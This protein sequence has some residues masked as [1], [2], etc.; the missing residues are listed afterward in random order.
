LGLLISLGSSSAINNI[1]AGLVI[2]YMR[3]FKIGDRI[4]IGDV[5]GDVIEKTMLVIR[6]RTIK[7]EDVTV[8]NSTV[9]SN[10]TTN[11]SAE[12]RGKGLIIYTTVTIGYDVPWKEMHQALI[13]AALRT[14]GVLKDPPPFVLQTALNDF[15]VSYQLNAYVND[16]NRQPEIY[17]G[18]HQNIQD[19]C[20]EAGIEIMSPHYT[21]VRDGNTTTIPENYRPQNYQ[22]K[23]FQVKEVRDEAP[24]SPKPV[25]PARDG[26]L[27]TN[28]VKAE[29]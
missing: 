20:S 12:A 1:I 23:A 13:N 6:I 8:P 29:K 22:P 16:A 3:P 14:E 15:F 27:Q 24:G 19:C 9:L 10:N 7:N 26:A 17:S 4:K 18:I 28:V 21:S 25:E 5:V 11:F 2:T